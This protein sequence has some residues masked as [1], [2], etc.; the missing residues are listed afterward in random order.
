MST[1]PEIAE[2]ATLVERLM[3]AVP[4]GGRQI[5][6]GVQLWRLTERRPPLPTVYNSSLCIVAQGSKF[7][8]LPTREYT[9]DAGHYLVSVMTVP[10]RSELRQASPKRPFLGIVIDLDLR[11]TSQLILAL[12]GAQQHKPAQP[13]ASAMAAVPIDVRFARTLL[14]LLDAAAAARTWQVLGR[15][16][17]REL[18]FL[19]L[20]GPRGDLLRAA[21]ALDGLNAP[22]ARAIG[23]IEQNL[24]DTIDLASLA[25]TAGL[26]R[27]ALHSQF[28]RATGQ[29][30]IQFMKKLRL[31]RANE[32]LVDGENVSQAALAVGYVSISQFSREFKRYFGVP[33]SQARH[34]VLANPATGRAIP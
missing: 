2:V 3:R 23:F 11:V 32:L 10:A 19:V 26:S 34:S 33:P 5:Q 22:V 20:E 8:R 28:K 25:K 27:S 21:V 7:A 14:R 13:E 9:Y 4:Q 15:S 16:L 12:D 18:H 30:P 31:H 24:T 17:L 1:L 29:S 6:P